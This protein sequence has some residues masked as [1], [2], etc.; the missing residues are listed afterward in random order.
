M[1]KIALPPGELDDGTQA[2][3]HAWV[4]PRTVPGVVDGVS[5]V[6]AGGGVPGDF[7]G[8]VVHANGIL[9]TWVDRA[10]DEDGY[11]IEVKAE[12][13]SVFTPAAVLQAGVNSAG[14]ITL[15]GEKVAE[16]RVRAFCWGEGSNVVRVRTGADVDSR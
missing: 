2:E 16:Y 8:T 10:D 6:R 4:T 3:D 11:L 15:P 12:G 9:F 13:A 1:R 14:L 7:R 5:S